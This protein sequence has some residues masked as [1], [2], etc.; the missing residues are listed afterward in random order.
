MPDLRPE[1]RLTDE[2]VRQVAALGFEDVPPDGLPHLNTNR[3]LHNEKVALAREVLAHRAAVPRLGHE[4]GERE[5]WREVVVDCL[6]DIR[7][8]C[9]PY[10]SHVERKLASLVE[11]PLAA[12]SPGQGGEGNLAVPPSA[13]C[14]KCGYHTTNVFACPTCAAR[15][16]GDDD[17]VFAPTPDAGTTTEGGEG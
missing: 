10:L 12:T 2:R 13:K 8:R 14:P 5:A 16:R 7:E 3:R 6:A 11:D 1:E 4:A 15:T 17:P 9:N